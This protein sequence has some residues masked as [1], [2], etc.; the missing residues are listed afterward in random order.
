M[1]NRRLNRMGGYDYSQAGCYF[2]TICAQDRQC[3]FG[4]IID[5]KMVLNEA[6]RRVVNWWRETENK[7]PHVELDEYVLMPNHLHGIVIIHGAFQDRSRPVPTR[8][9]KTKSLSELIG[10]FK[11]TSSKQIRENGFASFKWQRSFHD[12]IVRDDDDLNRVREY[13]LNN[14]LQWALDAE[15]PDNRAGL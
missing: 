1:K 4:E 10:A 3:L 9:T 6:G 15:N 14:P 5:D 11:T 7:F 2:V 13:I 12:H 8:T